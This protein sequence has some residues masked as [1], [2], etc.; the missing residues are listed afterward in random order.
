MDN[1]GRVQRDNYQMYPPMQQ[2]QQP[3]PVITPQLKQQI[4]DFIYP[5]IS[6]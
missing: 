2:I 3:V 1:S 5:T 6:S 4:G